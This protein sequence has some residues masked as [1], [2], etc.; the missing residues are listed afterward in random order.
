MG[1]PFKPRIGDEEQTKI[2]AFLSAPGF[3][4]PTDPLLLKRAIDSI[5][6]R[7]RKINPGHEKHIRGLLKHLAKYE[8]CSFE[9][10]TFREETFQQTFDQ[11]SDPRLPRGHWIGTIQYQNDVLAWYFKTYQFP[12]QKRNPVIKKEWLQKHLSFIKWYLY[13][14][15]CSCD[16]PADLSEFFKKNTENLTPRQIASLLLSEIH[17]TTPGNIEKLLKK[18]P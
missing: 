17:Y 13:S 9:D 18:R 15:E 1:K 7:F 8:H 10:S 11:M 2:F 16:Y 14:W 4:L 6:L 3:H 5:L 12:L